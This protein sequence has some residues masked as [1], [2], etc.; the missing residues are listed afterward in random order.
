MKSVGID[1]GSY[2]IKVAE[3]ESHSKSVALT[4]YFEIPLNPQPGQDVTLTRIEALREVLRRYP[5]GSCKV[6]VGIR[7]EFVSVRHK[8][9]PFRERHKLLR[10]IPF[11][12]E[13]EVP[14]DASDAVFDA[15]VIRY[16]GRGAEVLAVVAPKAPVQELINLTYD[17]GI[18]P[19]IISVEGLAIANLL[20]P[21]LD[22]PPEG[23]VE[24]LAEG[25]EDNVSNEPATL[26]L[27]MGHTR[28]LSAVM[29]GGR[30]ITSRA[31]YFGGQELIEAI[32][33]RYDI[34]YHEAVKAL[35]ERGFVLTSSEGSTQDQK[36]FSEVIT[37]AL[38][39]LVDDL[40]LSLLDMRSQ[41]GI[42]ISQIGVLGGVSSLINLAP[43]LTSRLELPVNIIRPVSV[44]PR[45]D[46]VIGDIEDRRSLV[47]FGLALE[48]LRK[49]R[50]PA[51][52]L[53]RGEF[54]KESESPKMLWQRWRRTV[55][56]AT[57]CIAAFY[58][59]TYVKEDLAR[60]ADEIAQEAMLQQGKDS[61]LAK[62][63][64][65]IS[66]IE[67]HLRD[68]RR[69]IKDRQTLVKMKD[70]NSGLDVLDAISK[71]LPG[72]DRLNVDVRRFY[73]LENKLSI[74]G[75]VNRREEATQLRNSL[76]LLASD[77]KVKELQP[78]ISAG[79]RV[80]FAFE[81]NVAR[82]SG[83]GARQ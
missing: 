75:L 26:I 14:F 58:V 9:F 70:Y 36:I 11:E 83:K 50:Y 56:F 67:R 23:P 25:S 34:P 71:G 48:G 54:A 1:I 28:T 16:R 22:T 78:S 46:F 39:R 74:E 77:K 29:H 6:V 81:L 3:V 15:R 33:K 65:N 32:R 66:G 63:Q 62:N 53:R 45:V 12:L 27:D 59:Y 42:R 60:R 17:A 40:R 18:D 49:P 38:Q 72:Q 73:L 43:Y 24:T 35:E 4:N 80:S 21:W 47:A 41:Y 55:Q 82:F 20:E 52:N 79:G 5:P 44:F 19:D 10:S 61:G 76:R 13:D 30:L 37:G 7:Q 2:R 8:T 57:A 69:E 68:K 51:I 64:L 31:F